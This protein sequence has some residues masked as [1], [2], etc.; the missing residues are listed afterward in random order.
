MGSQFPQVGSHLEEMAVAPGHKESFSYC[1][2]HTV[3]TQRMNGWGSGWMDK[4][5][6]E[7]KEGQMDGWMLVSQVGEQT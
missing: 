3:G 6:S 4:W 5:I 7:R 2:W 1:T